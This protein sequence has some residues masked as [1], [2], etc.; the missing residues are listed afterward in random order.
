MTFL[1]LPEYTTLTKFDWKEISLS[2]QDSP[3]FVQPFKTETKLFIGNAIL[4]IKILK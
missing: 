2:T 4:N 1:A 3:Y